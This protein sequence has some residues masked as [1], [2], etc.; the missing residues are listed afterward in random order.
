MLFEAVIV[1]HPIAG[2][3]LRFQYRGQL[4]DELVYPSRA[5]AKRD[6]AKMH[7]K[8]IMIGWS[9]HPASSTLAAHTLGWAADRAGDPQLHR[10]RSTALL[11]VGSASHLRHP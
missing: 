5:D 9:E 2:V 11:I 7:R 8:L 10:E 1:E 6:S 4:Y 3:V